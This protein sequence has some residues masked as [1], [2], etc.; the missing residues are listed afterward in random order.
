[1]SVERVSG[2]RPISR[3][4]AG[5]FVLAAVFAANPALAQTVDPTA[6]WLMPHGLVATMNNRLFSGGTVQ[7]Q[8]CFWR[9]TRWGKTVALQGDPS[10]TKYDI[11]VDAGSRP[12][13]L[14]HLS[15]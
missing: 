1:M 3:A 4:L 6:Y 7:G 9:G 11:F 13:V 14:G 5:L 2:A 8:R 15:R 12:R 10:M